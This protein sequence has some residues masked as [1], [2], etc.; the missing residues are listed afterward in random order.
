MKA[1]LRRSLM[2]HPI[3]QEAR[4]AEEANACGKHAPMEHS[5]RIHKVQP[6]YCGGGKGVCE[7]CF[8]ELDLFTRFN[9]FCVLGN[10]PAGQSRFP[11]SEPSSIVIHIRI[12]K[13]TS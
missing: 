8:L 5:R 7:Y 10:D 1:A 6:L 3:F 9:V 11:G 2:D 13:S 12:Y 4:R